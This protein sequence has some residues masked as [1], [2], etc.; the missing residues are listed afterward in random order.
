MTP[1]AAVTRKPHKLLDA[2]ILVTGGLVLVV[3]SLVVPL[4]ASAL[5]VGIALSI[6]TAMLVLVMA[7]LVDKPTDFQ[8]FPVL[9]L[10]SLVIRL[11]LNVSSTRL[12]LTE[13]QNGKQAAGQVING[14]AEFAAGGS[15]LVGLTVFAVISVVNFMVITKGSGRMA[16]VAARFALDSLPGKQLAIDGDLNAGAIDHNEAKRRRAAE[17]QE[18]SFFGSLDGASKFVKGDAIAG[19]VITLINLIVGLSVGVAVHGMPV[20]EAAATYSHLTIGDGLVSQIPALITSMAAALLLSRGGATDTTA[21]L[22]SNE[23]GRNWRPAAMVA[24]GMM[25]VTF[26]PGMPKLVFLSL[27]ASFAVIAWLIF[28]RASLAARAEPL[29]PPLETAARPAARMGDVLDTDEISVEIGADLVLTALDQARGLGSRITNLR[30]HVAR[31]FGLILPDVRI[32]DTDDLLPNDYLIR[33]QGVVR[34]RGTLRPGQVLALGGDVLSE[35]PGT[36]VREPVYS[37]PAKWLPAEQQENA[38]LLGATVVTP[39][40]VL[41]TH[42]MEVVKAH[43]AALMNLSALQRQMD[44]LRNLSDPARAER[45]RKYFETMLPEKVAPETLLAILRALLEERIPIRNLTQI[46]DALSEFR[47]VEA[48][49]MLY[50]LVRKRLR[51]QIT[52]H[53]ADEAGR[54][55]AIQLHP[56][57]EAEFVRA[58]AE[59]GRAGGGAMTPAISSRL[60]EST[61]KVLADPETAAR[62]VIVAP[63]HRRRMIRA[64]LGANGIPVPVLGLE[65]ID[66][67][68][69][70]H[71]LAT[72]E[73]A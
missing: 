38:A 44:E 35:L 30:I 45:Y 28:R 25:I 2:P 14:F 20:A 29:A 10:V 39:M 21:D 34:G 7:S 11:S 59:T 62:G 64:V 1:I 63:D 6:A 4:P 33:I 8:A 42:L 3:I 17:Q 15:I 69:D 55:S 70:L 46:I 68:A 58:D 57:W 53:F 56:S 5:D 66:P 48:P 22:L 61:R 52:Q 9:L 47:G 60:L 18:I 32:T 72:I 51:G 19:I 23:F 37:S 31:S 26:V 50:E 36:Q 13:G 65:E 67:A 16:E 71:L 54:I 27:A 24:G 41:S 43:L 49:E 73:A 12:I 40:E